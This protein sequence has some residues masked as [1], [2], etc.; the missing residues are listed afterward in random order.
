MSL[1]LNGEAGI[2]KW[3][4]RFGVHTHLDDSGPHVTTEAKSRHGRGLMLSL[5]RLK[6]SET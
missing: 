5:E 3:V 2:D 4:C 1:E 6:C